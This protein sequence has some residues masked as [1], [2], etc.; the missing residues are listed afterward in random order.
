[1]A[2]YE[3]TAINEAGKKYTSHYDGVDS[4]QKLSEELAKMGDTLVKARKNKAK[5]N[6]PVKINDSEIVTFAYRFAGMYSAGLP[7]DS[8]FRTIEDQTENATFRDIIADVRQSI[9]TGSNLKESFEKHKGVFSEFFVGM[10]EAG[11]SGGKL[12][13]SLETSANYLERRSDLKRKVRSAFAYPLVV[14]VLSIVMTTCLVTFIVPIFAKLYSQLNVKLPGPTQMLLDLS[15][16]FK[17]HWPA[18]ILTLGITIFL[19]LH[20]KRNV[21]FKKRWDVWKLHIPFFAK[22][23]RMITVANYM[24]TFSMLVSEGVDVIKSFEVSQ[25]VADNYK[26]T[27]VSEEVKHAVKTGSQVAPA[28]M[29]HDIFPPIIIQMASTGEET[30]SLGEML[31]KGVLFMER[32]IE[33]K[34]NRLLVKLE[35]ALTL[36]M[37]FLVGFILL[38]VYLPMFDYIAQIK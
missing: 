24:R 23:I 4:V 27:Q 21:F 16:L 34:I 2:S 1:M 28:L 5:R 35:P 7:I 31:N 25:V 12:S 8:C 36:V 26:M 19:F 11:E 32:D 22:L 17:H 38:S 13:R 14:G 3:Y 20:T 10:L 18:I 15:M 6:K 33:E 29:K 30:G 9:E 37:G